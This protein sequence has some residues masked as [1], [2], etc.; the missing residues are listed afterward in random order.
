MLSPFNYI[1]YIDMYIVLYLNKD[2]FYC[3][4][5]F[6]YYI[7]Y[8]IFIEIKFWEIIDYLK[9]LKFVFYLKLSF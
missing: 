1:F 2:S 5:F 7:F 6:V 4:I 8:N 9:N 3:L